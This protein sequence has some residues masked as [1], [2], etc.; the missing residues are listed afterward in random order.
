MTEWLHFHFSLA[1]IGEGN[2]NPLQCS[3][4]ENPRDR[5]AWWA[6]VYGVAQSQ[7]RVKSLSS[8]S[9]V[10]SWMALP[11]QWTW[12]WANSRIQWGMGRPGVLQRMGLQRSGHDFMTEQQVTVTSWDEKRTYKVNESHFWNHPSSCGTRPKHFSVPSTSLGRLGGTLKTGQCNSAGRA[13]A[14]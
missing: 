3:C 9:R 7:T 13:T 8:S 10:I 12:T 11:I 1:C 5:E 2:G 14:L 6:A 4:W